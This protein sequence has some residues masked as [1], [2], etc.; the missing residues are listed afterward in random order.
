VAGSNGQ[1]LNRFKIELRFKDGHCSDYKVS[2]PSITDTDWKSS[3]LIAM[4]D[5]GKWNGSNR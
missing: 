5:G 3:E 2:G 4:R 1:K